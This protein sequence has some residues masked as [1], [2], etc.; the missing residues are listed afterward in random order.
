MK[1]GLQYYVFNI[2]G[3]GP[4]HIGGYGRI[5]NFSH[6]VTVSETIWKIDGFDRPSA[7][8]PMSREEQE[9][10]LDENIGGLSW[11]APIF[12]NKDHPGYEASIWTRTDKATAMYSV[13]TNEMEFS[14]GYPRR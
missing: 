2:G 10:F 3:R 13:I 12:V 9:K 1:T 11:S 6:G 4:L 8:P 14:A 5:T 7:R